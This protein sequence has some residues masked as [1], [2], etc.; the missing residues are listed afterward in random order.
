MAI[1]RI[2]TPLRPLCGG[3]GEVEIPGATVDAVLSNL[4]D[5]HP[6]FAE[7]LY[8]EDSGKLRRFVNVYVGEEDIRFGDGID[9]AVAEADVVSIVPAVA[10]G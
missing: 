3:E 2:P 10:G 5:A 4:E 7:R 1:V 8:D 6:G 9:T